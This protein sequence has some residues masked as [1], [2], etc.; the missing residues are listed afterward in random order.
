MRPRTAQ[1]LYVLA[2]A[3]LL[4]VLSYGITHP[5]TPAGRGCP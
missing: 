3:T 5:W 2:V 4:G 1:L